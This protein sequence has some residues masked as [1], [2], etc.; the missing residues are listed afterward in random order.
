MIAHK[1]FRDQSIFS[2]KNKIFVVF[3]KME[4]IIFTVSLL[5]CMS[6]AVSDSHFILRR[7]AAGNCEPKIDER[8]C[9][10]RYKG[11]CED[12]GDRG[13][14]TCCFKEL[15]EGPKSNCLQ[16][17]FCTS[18]PCRN[19]ATCQPMLG[20]YFCTCRAA[21][22]HGRN[23]EKGGV[24]GKRVSQPQVYFYSV[25][26]YNEVFSFFFTIDDYFGDNFAFSFTIG[27]VT[28]EG[29][30][31][32]LEEGLLKNTRL[33]DQSLFKTQLPGGLKK[34]F[35]FIS[36]FPKKKDKDKYTVGITVEVKN[37]EEVQF[38]AD[39]NVYVVPEAGTECCP[40]IEM[41]GCG[42]GNVN[43]VKMQRG[44]VYSI[45]S[46]ISRPC[47]ET[48]HIFWQLCS[49]D[50]D[51]PFPLVE[52][53]KE[54]TFKSSRKKPNCKI[55]NYHETEFKIDAY[56]LVYGVYAFITNAAVTKCKLTPGNMCWFSVVADS[57]IAK[58]EGGSARVASAGFEL[59]MDA[60][61]STDPNEQLGNN[62]HLV[63]KWTCLPENEELCSSVSKQ[64]G[65][66]LRLQALEGNYTFTVK[67]SV[68]ESKAPTIGTYPE[69]TLPGPGTATQVVTVI[70][71]VTGLSIRCVKNC[72]RQM[73]S[74]EVLYLK[75]TCNTYCNG[76]EGNNY[77]KWSVEGV[78][79]NE[80][81]TDLGINSDKLIVREK[82]FSPGSRYTVF[83]TGGHS[84][85]AEFVV[86]VKRALQ[87]EL[88]DKGCVVSPK[89]GVSG[90]DYF[91][92]KCDFPEESL[93]LPL[94]F[95][96]FQ[97]PDLAKPQTEIM[98]SYSLRPEMNDILL[99]A[100]TEA[101]NYA[102][103][104]FVR[105]EDHVGEFVKKHVAT[106]VV[107]PVT[108]APNFVNI[109]E[110][111]R[112][113]IAE[114]EGRP[115]LEDYISSGDMTGAVNLVSLTTVALQSSNF[116]DK[117]VWLWKQKF[118]D[119]IDKFK[120]ASAKV[121][122]SIQNIGKAIMHRL[123]EEQSAK[124]LEVDSMKSWIKVDKPSNLQDQL[125][126]TGD[127]SQHVKISKV[128]AQAMERKSEYIGIQVTTMQENPFVWDKE[129][130]VNTALIEIE[131]YDETISETPE[132][133]TPIDLY[134]ST[135]DN[136]SSEA[137]E[138]QVSVPLK[139]AHDKELLDDCIAVHKIEA[140]K[141][142]TPYLKFEPFQQPLYKIQYGPETAPE[143]LHCQCLHLSTFSGSLLAASAIE[144]I[145]HQ[146]SILLFTEENF[147]ILSFAGSFLAVF[148]FLLIWTKWADNR[149]DN[150]GSY[151]YLV[152]V[153]TGWKWNAGTTANVGIQ[154]IGES[155]RGSVHILKDTTRR[156][157]ARNSDSWFVIFG[158]K[159]LGN[160]QYLHLWHDNSG[161]SA[162]W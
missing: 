34:I 141:G 128:L 123:G 137:V 69:K 4:N 42:E 147:I 48:A 121:M 10:C 119:A 84:G 32:L 143:E 40:V 9:R 66:K 15:Y 64:K 157:H 110:T 138:G 107:K 1:H 83:V 33:A 20:S 150:Q 7:D 106:V 70:K 37:T 65:S 31:A 13:K 101:N 122:T 145:F 96:L 68:D 90:I 77:Y 81:D 18:N 149:D 112:K 41:D 46:T 5:F 44:K 76:S 19:S 21:D 22:Y 115:S 54:N 30:S 45:R 92:C 114:D 113:L 89:E 125:L 148:F 23:C 61:S 160:L 105:V 51:V 154:L 155:C 158:T 139:A 131:I 117:E 28:I 60:S 29:N 98:I 71:M 153:F 11:L 144:D 116:T 103:N 111:M 152:G 159:D 43:M 35:Y 62:A 132:I 136:V 100:G 118:L 127:T 12:P 86:V 27:G 124:L 26:A 87:T 80:K 47:G 2:I 24:Q 133:T 52:I 58:L 108:E 126:G 161:H 104:I 74:Q 99:A 50:R 8:G 59:V 75:V 129:E 162:P 16:K 93:G 120:V 94:R 102:T 91:N 36:S 57:I 39:Y 134:V 67:V 109:S 56:S 63:Y 130:S 17:N 78:G 38:S 79:L 95:E 49:I 156:V 82:F 135:A 14:C 151:A 146:I 53:F 73:N 55:L 3:R 25:I 88:G 142:Q 6:H 72:D 97:A 140:K 85:R